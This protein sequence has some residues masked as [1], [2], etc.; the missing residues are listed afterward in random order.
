MCLIQNYYCSTFVII[1]TN[2]F[3]EITSHGS[4]RINRTSNKYNDAIKNYQKAIDLKADYDNAYKNLGDLLRKQNQLDNAIKC[5]QKVLEIQPDAKGIYRL[6]GD[7]LLKRRK[8]I[9]M[10]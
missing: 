10:L 5:Y 3:E 8:S 4:Q 9:A 6:I 1:D 2:W 7:I